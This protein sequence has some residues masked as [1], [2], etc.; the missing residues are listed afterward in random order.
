MT[1]LDLLRELARPAP[2]DHRRLTP[3]QHTLENAARLAA[4]GT[5]LGLHCAGQIAIRAIDTGR[6]IHLIAHLWR[7]R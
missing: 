7:D 2:H 1:P 3:T 4:T 6:T 5:I